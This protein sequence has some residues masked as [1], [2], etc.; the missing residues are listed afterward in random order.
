ME[1][2]AGEAGQNPPLLITRKE[3]EVL[4]DTLRV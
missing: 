4:Y 1:Q 2:A 3:V